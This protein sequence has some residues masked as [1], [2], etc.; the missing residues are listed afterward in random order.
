MST[1]HDALELI[2]TSVCAS[3]RFAPI[4][5]LIRRDGRLGGFAS[6]DWRIVA[7]AASPRGGQGQHPMATALSLWRAG[8]A[9][10]AHGTQTLET[11]RARRR[12]IQPAGPEGGGRE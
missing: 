2:H 9:R 5:L 4:L 10:L 1:S 6:S 7:R 8:I 11:G 3:K 12:L